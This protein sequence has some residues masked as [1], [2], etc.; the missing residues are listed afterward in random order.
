M[1]R[2]DWG[3]AQVVPGQPAHCSGA[4]ELLG[5]SAEMWVQVLR[6]GSHPCDAGVMAPGARQRDHKRGLLC[7][8]R[9][10]ADGQPGRLCYVRWRAAVVDS[11]LTHRIAR[12]QDGTLK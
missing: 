1:E 10:C 9:V 7:E 4:R 8:R 12:N 6:C 2:A 11:A 3:G 5:L